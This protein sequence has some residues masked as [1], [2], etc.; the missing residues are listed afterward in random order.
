MHQIFLLE[1]ILLVCV[2]K[3]FSPTL[4]EFSRDTDPSAM[5][6]LLIWGYFQAA[7]YAFVALNVNSAIWNLFLTQLPQC[8]LLSHLMSHIKPRL[9][10]HALTDNQLVYFF[11]I[12][13][14]C[15]IHVMLKIFRIYV[16]P[17]LVKLLKR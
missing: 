17:C 11:L 9:G 4:D 2:G 16:F 10:D 5:R 6:N 8:L 15:L 3:D 14:Y 1:I 12:F 13:K 7:F